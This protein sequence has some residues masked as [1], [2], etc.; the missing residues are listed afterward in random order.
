MAMTDWEAA[1]HTAYPASNAKR[2]LNETHGL[3]S[4]ASLQ[5]EKSS[6]LMSLLELSQLQS[7]GPPESAQHAAERLFEQETEN[8]M[9]TTTV[10][11]FKLGICYMDPKDFINHTGMVWL[12]RA[13]SIVVCL[14]GGR[15][16]S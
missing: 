7:N 9:H 2:E 4:R 1:Y 6:G 8:M 15:K 16:S 14:F 13:E 10:K 5:A 12:A 3:G 11:L